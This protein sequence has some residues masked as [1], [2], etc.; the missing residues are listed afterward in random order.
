MATPAE[1]FAAYADPNAASLDGAASGPAAPR[2]TLVSL[3]PPPRRQ[4]GVRVADVPELVRR[5]REE[6]RLL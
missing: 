6:A 5:L 3:A 4:A 2:V 1:S